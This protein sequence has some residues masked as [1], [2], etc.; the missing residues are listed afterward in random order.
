MHQYPHQWWR[1]FSTCIFCSQRSCEQS[2]A[3][4]SLLSTYVYRSK[5]LCL[6]T[7]FM[8]KHSCVASTQRPVCLMPSLHKEDDSELGLTLL[9]AMSITMCSANDQCE[10]S[11]GHPDGRISLPSMSSWSLGGHPGRWY[12][13]THCLMVSLMGEPHRPINP[14]LLTTPLGVCRFCLMWDPSLGCALCRPCESRADNTDQ[15]TCAHKTPLHAVSQYEND[16]DW[17]APLRQSA[18]STAAA[19]AAV[20]VSILSSHIPIP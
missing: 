16:L 18:T 19:T 10:L 17:G 15:P 5:Y 2:G 3:Q 4:C 6:S 12:N 14:R 1:S 13:N 20:R 11:P 9:R 7:I 8:A